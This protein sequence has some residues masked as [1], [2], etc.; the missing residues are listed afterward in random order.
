[1]PRV[2]LP[3]GATVDLKDPDD[4]MA[5]DLFAVVAS[6]KVRIPVNHTFALDDVVA[7]HKLLEG[8]GTTGS[9]VLIP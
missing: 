6:G 8:R 2:T 1:M 3:S 4:Y 7:A 9:T 5:A